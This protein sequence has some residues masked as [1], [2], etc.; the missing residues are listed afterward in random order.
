MSSTSKVFTLIFDIGRSAIDGRGIEKYF[1]WLKQTILVFEDLVVYHDGCLSAD[2]F[3]NCDLRKINKSELNAFKK[4]HD[5]KSVLDK[6]KPI[7]SN[8]ITFRLVEYSLTQYS[9]F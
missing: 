5:V 8:D 6:L 9:K 1:L 7:A 3:P 2:Q 4:I